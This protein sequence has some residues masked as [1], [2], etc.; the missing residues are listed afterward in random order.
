[1]KDPQR[2]GNGEP[3]L[4]TAAGAS[5]PRTELTP[6]RRQESL[7]APAA[8][9]QARCRQREAAAAATLRQCCTC[10]LG[11]LE[12]RAVRC[13]LSGL[14]A[15]LLTPTMHIAGKTRG[16]HSLE[17]LQQGTDAGAGAFRFHTSVQTCGN[18]TWVLGYCV[19]TS[20]VG[21]QVGLQPSLLRCFRQQTTGKD[22]YPDGWMWNA[23]HDNGTLLSCSPNAVMGH[24]TVSCTVVARHTP[25]P[26]SNHPGLVPAD[27]PAPA[28]V[29][30]LALT[31]SCSFTRHDGRQNHA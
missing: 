24:A 28:A 4:P 12:E 10:P 1:M 19:A 11:F 20:S 15:D 31:E 6:R 22:G 5:L 17:Q 2:H 21:S 7:V 3:R 23:V 8:A 16:R 9:P 27:S 18:G 26:V 29:V 14:F 13:Q 30:A 25:L